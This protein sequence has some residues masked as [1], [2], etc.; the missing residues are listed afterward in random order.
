VDVRQTLL[1]AIHADPHDFTAWLALS[2]HLEE[3]GCAYQGELLRLHLRLTRTWDDPDRAELEARA[4]KLIAAGVTPYVPR[5]DFPLGRT[6]LTVALMPA[7]RF[8]MGD[9]HP[10]RLRVTISKPFYFGIYPITQAQWRAVMGTK[11][12]KFPG[13]RRPAEQTN[14]DDCLDFCAKLSRQIGRHVRL[15]SE[16]EWEYACRAGTTTLYHSG[17]SEA[18]LDRVAFRPKHQGAGSKAGKPRQ[19]TQTTST[20]RVGLKQPNGW[21][22]YDLH[23]NVW[24]WTCDADGSHPDDLSVDPVRAAASSARVCKGG[25]YGN[26][27]RAGNRIGFMGGGRNDFIGCRVLIDWQP[28]K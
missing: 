12:A 17:D 26:P 9:A 6:S 1:A 15:P 3:E 25:S 18:D 7:G 20:H 27:T 21:G 13:A 4:Q 24:E 16:A 23:G 19:K 2:D 8:R 5:L 10:P 28:T 14:Y 22:L 11:P